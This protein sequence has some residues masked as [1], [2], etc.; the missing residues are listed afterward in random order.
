MTDNHSNI[1]IYHS[2]V[3]RKISQ[4][5]REVYHLKTECTVS[6]DVYKS[7]CCVL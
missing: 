3:K 5:K 2:E 4:F 6:L 7:L 1:V